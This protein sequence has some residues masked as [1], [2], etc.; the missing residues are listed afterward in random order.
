MPR[1]HANG[2]LLGLSCV[3]AVF[4]GACGDKDSA[5]MYPAKILMVH[6]AVHP[7]LPGEQECRENGGRGRGKREMGHFLN[8]SFGPY[9]SLY[10]HMSEVTRL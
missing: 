5:G 9:G 4:R 8:N 3:A 2:S 10:R 6:P 7:D 1:Q